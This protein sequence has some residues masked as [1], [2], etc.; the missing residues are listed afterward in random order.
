MFKAESNIGHKICRSGDLAINTMWAFMGALGVAKQVGLVSPSYG[1]YRPL[2]SEDLL[3][4]Y[5]DQLLRTQDYKADTCVARR[6]F[7]LRGFDYIQMSF[8]GFQSCAHPPMNKPPSSGSSIT[9]T[10]ES[11]VTSGPSGSSSRC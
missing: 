6:G 3:P 9:P 8:F 7:D 4:D 5:V 1:I 10:G 2:T 11:G